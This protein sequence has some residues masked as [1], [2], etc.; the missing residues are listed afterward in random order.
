MG[1]L[2]QQCRG[3]TN[4]RLEL[5]RPNA[6]YLP[7]ETISGTISYSKHTNASVLLSGAIHFKKRKKNGL[8]KC[9]IIF[10][11]TEFDLFL[12]SNRKQNFQLHLD[13][14]L[15]PSFNDIDTYP[16]VS[17]SISLIHKKSKD[18]IYSSIPIRVCPR[19]QIDRP[20]LLTPL[21]FGPVENQL[22][23]I[24]LEVK[25]NRAIFTFDDI[26]Q[27]Y[28]ELQN[29]NEE[30]ILKTE[31]SLGVYYIIESNVCQEDLCNGIENFST[32]STK[33]K[34][35]R[36]KVLLH[37]PKKNYLPPTYKFQYGREGDQ[38]SFNLVIDYKIQFKVYLDNTDNLWQVDIPIVLCNDTLEQTE[39]VDEKTEIDMNAKDNFE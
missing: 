34:L 7:N 24:K 39:I 10:F 37:I 18:Q 8:E 19:V 38:S 36:N 23:G 4:N 12:S 26:I 32:I 3:I 6:V 21:F 5:D 22:T 1:N 2:Q 30:F 16:N 25:V 35:I 14:H 29:P 11:T 9:R 15:P 27:I 17:Y 28:Y 13:E 20:L 33:R 31:I